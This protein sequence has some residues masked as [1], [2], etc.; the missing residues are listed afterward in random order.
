ME[1]LKQSLKNFDGEWSSKKLTTLLSMAMCAFMAILDQLT[2][3][4]LNETA[5]LSFLGMAGGQSLLN[6][7]SN[8]AH[9]VKAKDKD[10]NN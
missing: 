9:Q 3:Y 5:F 4:K 10:A 7:I 1:I 2:I 8:I 6:T